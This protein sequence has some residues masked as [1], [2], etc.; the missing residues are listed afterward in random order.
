MTAI[1]RGGGNSSSSEFTDLESGNS[2]LGWKDPWFP[3]F[4]WE[5]ICRCALD[6]C[7]HD[8]KRGINRDKECRENQRSVP[9]PRLWRKAANPPLHPLH[10]VFQCN[11]WPFS[12]DLGQS[13]LDG[14]GRGLLAWSTSFWI[15]WKEQA[16]ENWSIFHIGPI[17]STIH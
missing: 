9:L 4:R 10:E 11:Y 1:T 14:A 13:R 5:R 8:N 7:E 3:A 2:P 16:F 6:P 17:Y 12:H 15:E